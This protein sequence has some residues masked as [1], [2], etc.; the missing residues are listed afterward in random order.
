MGVEPTTATLATWPARCIVPSP[1]TTCGKAP[2]PVARPLP[3]KAEADPDLAHIIIA[4]PDL[5]DHIGPAVLAL[6]GTAR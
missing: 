3:T 6:V 4:W 5:P 2:D 1:Q